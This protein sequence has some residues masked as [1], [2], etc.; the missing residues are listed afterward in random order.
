VIE[1]LW[2]FLNWSISEF[3]Q[4]IPLDQAF[5]EYRWSYKQVQTILGQAFE[6]TSLKKKIG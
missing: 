4:L 1:E 5:M 6:P 3:W 2:Q